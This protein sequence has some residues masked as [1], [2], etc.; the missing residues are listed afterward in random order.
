MNIVTIPIILGGKTQCTAF[1]VTNAMLKENYSSKRIFA[2][3]Y[4]LACKFYLNHLLRKTDLRQ[5][6]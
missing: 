6:K 2:H 4:I 5:I 1:L 3:V